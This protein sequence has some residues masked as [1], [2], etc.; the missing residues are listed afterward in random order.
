[1]KIGKLANFGP[2]YETFSGF[3]SKWGYETYYNIIFGTNILTFDFFIIILELLNVILTNSSFISCIELDIVH[4]SPGR[5]VRLF[6]GRLHFIFCFFSDK[7]HTHMNNG[8]KNEKSGNAPDQV[9]FFLLTQ[10]RAHISSCNKENIPT[11]YAG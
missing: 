6:W 10:L 9:S 3:L 11:G 5:F 8:F 1:M 2:G 7:I 4:I